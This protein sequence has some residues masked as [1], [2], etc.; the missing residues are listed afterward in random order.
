M[1]VKKLLRIIYISVFLLA[2]VIPGVWTFVGTQKTIGNEEEVSFSDANYLNIADKIERYMNTK[3]GFRNDL[4]N[5]NNQIKYTVFGESGNK[6]VVVGK[7]DW[8]F[9]AAAL[10]DYTG[11]NTLSDEEL[12]GI[13]NILSMA[14]GYVYTTGAEF[15]FTSAPNKMEI[16]GEYMPGYIVENREPGNYEKLFLKLEDSNVN[17]VDLK[18]L[19]LKEKNNYDYNLYYGG[20]SHWNEVGSYIA[21]RDIMKKLDLGY[22]DTTVEFN[23]I[24]GSF[25][26]DLDKML[27]PSKPGEEDDIKL[28][29]EYKFY[30]TSNFRSPDDLVITTAND[31][32]KNSLIMWRDSFGQF[33]YYMFAESFNAAEFRRE[34]PYNFTNI[35]EQ[36]A[37]V[38]E[39]VER[40]LKLLLENPP[41]I[42]HKEVVITTDEELSDMPECSVKQ[43]SGNQFISVEIDNMPKECIKVYFKISTE[44]DDKIYEAYP[45]GPNGNPCMYIKELPDNAKLS[46]MYEYNGKIYE[47]LKNSLD[48]V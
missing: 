8:L 33:Q 30:Y 24:E 7:E 21:Y 13:V 46:V 34:L 40:N 28:D 31:S 2:L 27:F 10:D 5:L 6:E 18:T 26:G 42:E 35:G 44:S 39:I 20:D 14:Q 37:V 41:V 45:S 22:N 48:C 32:E 12:N 38:I 11:M 19:L 43:V 36:D 29:M 15:V 23:K 1:S 4:V 9:Y 3:F 25:K 16:Y 47:S 17:H